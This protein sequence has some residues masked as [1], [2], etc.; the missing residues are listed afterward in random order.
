LDDAGSLARRKETARICALRVTWIG[1]STVLL[2]LDGVRLLTDPVFSR[3]L[4]HVRRVATPAAVGALVD[5][6][7]ALVSHVHYDHMD[8]RSLVRLGRSLPVV[9]PVGGGALLRR[10][11][12]THVTEVAVGD[13]VPIGAVNV[14]VTHAD[15]PARRGLLGRTTPSVGYLVSG[16]RRVYFA[17]DTGLFD[18]M[19]DLRGHV[20]VALLPVAGW[21]ARLPAGHLDPRSAAE[22]LRLVRP[23][24]AVPIHWGT[25]R[26][27]GM[28]R[29]AAR[30]RAPAEEFARHASELAPEVDVRIVPPGGTTE[31]SDGAGGAGPAVA[32]EP[33]EARP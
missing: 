22:A 3:Q 13:D 5:L 26:S 18:A 20:D 11:Q 24:V 15:H 4:A 29:E 28:S 33:T 32:G 19:A 23:Q 30:L 9:V 10:R 6:D 12:F 7:A 2:D 16:S 8:L 31:L 21:G 17:G 25:Y 1:H 27:L 14:R